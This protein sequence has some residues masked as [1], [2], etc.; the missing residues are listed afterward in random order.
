MQWMPFQEFVQQPQVQED[1]M[2]TKM[3]E[4]FKTRLGEMRCGLHPHHLMSKFDG[5][6]ATV[7]HIDVDEQGSNCNAN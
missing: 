5:G 2:F 7:Y 4:L 3:I 1:R 6:L